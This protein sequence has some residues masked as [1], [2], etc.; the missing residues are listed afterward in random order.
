[1]KAIVLVA[2]FENGLLDWFTVFSN[3][4]KARKR[5]GEVLKEYDLTEESNGENGYTILL[6]PGIPVQ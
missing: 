5:Y 1:M 2:V 6:E 4:G 3:I